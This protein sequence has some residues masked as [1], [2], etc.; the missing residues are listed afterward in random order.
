MFD[1][2]TFVSC[3]VVVHQRYIRPE[4][5]THIGIDCSKLKSNL[6]E[7]SGR[8]PPGKLVHVS[9]AA[10]VYSRLQ[11]SGRK[12]LL[13]FTFIHCILVGTSIF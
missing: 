8:P 12:V 4:S 2:N 10:A 7:V 11:K 3:Y 1:R 9:R 5:R 13:G 6:G